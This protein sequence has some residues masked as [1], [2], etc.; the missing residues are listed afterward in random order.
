MLMCVVVL[1]CAML[2]NALLCS[3][4]FRFS[5]F[6]FF[7]FFIF[8]LSQIITIIRFVFGTESCVPIC[9]LQD[10]G[11][12]LFRSDSSWMKARHTGEVEMIGLYHD[13]I[14]YDTI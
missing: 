5:I 13:S 1:R 10:T 4:T 8:L 11:A 2:H 9:T 3:A 6:H 7:T 12:S 14:L